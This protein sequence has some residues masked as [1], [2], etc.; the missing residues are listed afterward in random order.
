MIL[1]R[2]GGEDMIKVI[3][4][5]NFLFVPF[6]FHIDIFDGIESLLGKFEPIILHTTLKELETLAGRSSAKIQRMASAALEFVK[7]CKIVEVEIKHGESGDDVI[8]RIAKE[9]K[10][11]VA[12]ND[13]YLRRRLRKNGVPAIFV[14][15]RKHLEIEGY[16]PK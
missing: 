2:E 4:D 10:C 1:H 7:R 9:W 15:Q 3:I 6:Q 12:T 11:P 14:R 8:L 16:I 5:A 13:I